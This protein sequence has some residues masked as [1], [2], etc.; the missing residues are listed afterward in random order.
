MDLNKIMQMAMKNAEQLT[1]EHI[2]DLE[3]RKIA[4]LIEVNRTLIMARTINR[5]ISPQM[6]EAEF[7]QSLLDLNEYYCKEIYND[8]EAVNGIHEI[9]GIAKNNAIEILTIADEIGA[10]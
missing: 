1:K 4:E 5:L 8:D 3:Q 7:G 6:I 9:T 2:K 10:D